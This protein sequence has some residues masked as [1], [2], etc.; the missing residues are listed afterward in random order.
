MDEFIS[1]RTLLNS[2]EF[3]QQFRDN[4]TEEARDTNTAIHYIDEEG[5]YVEEWPA[6]GELYE[7]RYDAIADKIIRL[8]ALHKPAPLAL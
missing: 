7:V 3:K 4:V 2:K 8:Q 5:C 1:I 6:T